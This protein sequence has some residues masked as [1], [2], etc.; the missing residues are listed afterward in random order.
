ASVNFLPFLD[1]V[2]QSPRGESGGRGYEY[3]VSYSMPLAELP[4]VAVPE[5]SGYLDTYRGTNPMKLHTEYVGAVVLLLV[6][7]G[8]Y[9]ARK[10]RYWWL[11][12][13]LGLFALTLALGGST[14]IYRIWYELLP[15]TKRFRAPGIAFFVVA[16]ALVCMAA[17]ALERLAGQVER[18]RRPLGGTRAEADVLAALP[19]VLGGVV[20]AGFVLGGMVAVEAGPGAYRFALFAAAAA[21]VV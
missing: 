12:V 21:G 9:N 1:Y 13:G 10:N 18:R 15:G 3:S 20:L 2:A 19:W 8:F 7:I 5:A 11:F 14:P 6:A 17:I 16:F 4:A